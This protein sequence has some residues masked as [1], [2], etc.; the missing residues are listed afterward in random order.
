M[1][2]KQEEEE[3]TPSQHPERERDVLRNQIIGG[4]LRPTKA[5]AFIIVVAPTEQKKLLQSAFYCE[6]FNFLSWTLTA[7]RRLQGPGPRNL[8]DDP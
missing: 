5:D 1:E 3:E 2:E 4:R 7:S 8:L 6:I